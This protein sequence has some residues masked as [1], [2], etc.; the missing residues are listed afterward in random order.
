MRAALCLSSGSAPPF[1]TAVDEFLGRFTFRVHLE[2]TPY[3]FVRQVT[4]VQER[5]LEA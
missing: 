3:R 2:L 1:G 4:W 5:R